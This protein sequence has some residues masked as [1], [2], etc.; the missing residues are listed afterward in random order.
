MN[1]LNKAK[2]LLGRVWKSRELS[3]YERASQVVEGKF[4]GAPDRSSIAYFSLYKA[5]ST[6]IAGRLGRRI[7]SSYP[8]V[9]LESYCLK[10]FGSSEF[11]VLDMGKI[12]RTPGVFFASLRTPV[13][14]E[15]LSTLKVILVV[16]DPRDI[17]TSLYFSLKF[18]HAIEG[19]GM[20]R[21]RDSLQKTSIDEYVL[22]PVAEAF[23]ER[24]LVYKGWTDARN[25]CALRYEDIIANPAESEARLAEF[26]EIPIQT[27]HLFDK[28][29]FAVNKEDVMSHKRRVTPGDHLEKL[30]TETI[31]ELNRRLESSLVAW[32][33]DTSAI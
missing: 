4:Q 24:L 14:A 15:M 33:Y 23:S 17:L 28:S 6:F 3:P 16:R 1:I 18:S 26:L 10:K 7:L 22:G 12:L 32:G 20:K 8:R 13:P 25:V 31:R 11:S 29:D 21:H 19:S 9:D 27:G 2:L 30:K 5:G